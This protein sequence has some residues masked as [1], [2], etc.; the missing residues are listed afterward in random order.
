MKLLLTKAP[1]PINENGHLIACLIGVLSF[2]MWSMIMG[3][4]DTQTLPT[5]RLGVF[6]VY[7][8]ASFF[9]AI[10]A[11][12]FMWCLSNPKRHYL[13]IVATTLCLLIFE[14]LQA[15]LT[16]GRYDPADILVIAVACVFS[17][18][19]YGNLSVFPRTR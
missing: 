3:C 13:S 17:M 19:I 5:T 18:L 16:I 2:A 7:S 4:V 9:G 12:S 10:G 1:Q 8:G 6:V 15:H 11:I 14:L